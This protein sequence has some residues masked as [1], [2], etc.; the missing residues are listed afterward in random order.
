MATAAVMTFTRFIS[1]VGLKTWLKRVE[2]RTEN[3]EVDSVS[4]DSEYIQWI[5]GI[6][7]GRPSWCLEK[8]LSHP[9]VLIG[10]I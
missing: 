1:A 10:V 5:Q 3:E 4:T 8:V 9:C 7:G 6:V 2:E